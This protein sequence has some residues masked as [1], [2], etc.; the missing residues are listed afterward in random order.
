M[1]EGF[2]REHIAFFS[3]GL[4][5]EIR[6]AYREQTKKY[7]DSLRIQTALRA[8]WPDLPPALLAACM[9]QFA[10]QDRAARKCALPEHALLTPSALEM[11]SSA[12]TAALH[13]ALLPAHAVV[14]EIAAGIGA[15]SVAI[16]AHARLLLCCEADDVHARLL[17]HNLTLAG[18][19]NA[20]VLR[21][22]AEQLRDAVRL[23]RIDAVFADPARRGVTHDADD[24]RGRSRRV[25]NIEDSSPP[26]SFFESL[27]EHLSVLVK[28]A[29]ASDAPP[30]WNVATVAAGGECKE[31]LLHRNLDLPSLCA[32]DADSGARWIPG[33]ALSPRETMPMANIPP[34]S[35]LIEPHAAIIRTGAVAQYCREQGCEP[36]DPRIAYAWSRHD[37]PASSWHQRFRILHAA[38]YQRRALQ[39]LA[40]ELGFGPATEIKKRGFPETSEVVRKTLKLGGQR[41]G[42]VFLTRRGNEHWMLF[43][44]RPDA[45]TDS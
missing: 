7:A 45:T 3:S 38:K 39:R 13:A 17:A 6:A 44:L 26:F 43:A 19:R 37:A 16:A 5:T 22:R 24:A 18:V 11:A 42:V 8:Q 32:I 9:R 2:D 14:L 35:S 10:L 1:R 4:A 28:V 34:G 21:G 40:D 12:A 33:A 25:T 23:E 27:P 41:D 15:D 20:V 31:I 29:P 30:G 36:I